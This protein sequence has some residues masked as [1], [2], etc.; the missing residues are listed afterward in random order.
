MPPLRPR[1]KRRGTRGRRNAKVYAQTTSNVRS[2]APM[3]PRALPSSGYAVGVPSPLSADFV[4]HRSA[5]VFSPGRN[6]RHP[7]VDA[8]SVG[9]KLR[10]L[11]LL[12]EFAPYNL[13]APTVAPA[14]APGVQEIDEFLVAAVHHDAVAAV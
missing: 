13:A 11:E 6:I 2:A 1:A 14:L 10:G 12:S 8:L 4:R 5:P 9:Q 7:F 3:V